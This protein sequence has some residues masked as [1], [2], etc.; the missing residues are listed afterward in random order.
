[1]NSTGPPQVPKTDSCEHGNE[2][3]DIINDIFVL[4]GGNFLL[5]K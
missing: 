4:S 2:S 5:K 3:L 1:M